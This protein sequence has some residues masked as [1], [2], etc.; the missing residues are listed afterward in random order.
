M[1]LWQMSLSGGLLILAVALVRS[2][3]LNL[4]PKKTF[5]ILW[6]IAILRLLLPVSIPSLFSAW[7]FVP[8][9]EPFRRAGMEPPVQ[10]LLPAASQKTAPAAFLLLDTA[11]PPAQT[12][13]PWLALWAV[14]V[15][16]CILFFFISWIRCRLRFAVS[17]PVTENFIQDWIKTH[18]LPDRRI[19][20]VRQSD[21][22]R[23]PLT[24]GIFHP[25]ILLPKD[26]G[27][28]DRQTLSWILLHESVHIRRYDALTKLLSTFTLCIHW[29]NP[30]VYLMYFLMIQDLE[31]ACDE[32]VIQTAGQDSRSSYALTLIRL[33]EH[34]SGLFPLESRFCANAAEERITSTSILSSSKRS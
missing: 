23:T 20:R 16:I 31:L 33:E 18:P 19:I 5:L 14:G 32:S 27:W 7:S 10:L 15:G 4:L 13:S 24:Y 6:K 3:T 1:T 9:H 22:I 34:K 28:N 2:L 29:F 21:Q 12:I 17:L 26:T 30:A 8:S 25:V 11:S